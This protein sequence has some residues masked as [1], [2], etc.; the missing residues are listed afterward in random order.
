MAQNINVAVIT[1]NLT[2]DPELRATGGGTQIA[3]LRVAVNGRKKSADGQWVDDPNFF[4]VTVFGGN[5]ENVARYLSK[6]SGVAVDGRLN[7]REWTDKEGNRRQA[8]GIIADNVQFLNSG[9]G[10]GQQG[11]A[12]QISHQDIPDPTEYSSAAPPVPAQHPDD[13]IPF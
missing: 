13:D 1:G 9:G 8:V 10:G 4:D 12:R 3:S 11:G 2:S 6:G 7:W 5:A